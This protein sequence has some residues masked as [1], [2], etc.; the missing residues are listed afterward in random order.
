MRIGYDLL[1]QPTEHMNNE[2]PMTKLP[3]GS[4]CFTATIMS[5]EEAMALPISKRP[6]NYRISSEIYHAVFESIG[7]ASMCWNPRPS[8]EVFDSEGAA[9]IA[10]NLCLKIADEVERVKPAEVSSV[11]EII[12]INQCNDNYQPLGIF[13]TLADAIAVVEENG[14]EICINAPEDWAG[15]E[16]KERI[17]GISDNGR[18]VWKRSWERIFEDDADS[19]K[20]RWRVYEKPTN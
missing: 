16:I 18:T 17:I 4:G 14:Q 1:M 7:A 6:L 19:I 13:T 8:N 10:T 2:T 15:V 9:Q 11:F 12:E 3:D 20:A 5:R